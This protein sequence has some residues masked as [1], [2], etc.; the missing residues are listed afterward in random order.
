M[1]TL[2]S[3]DKRE[4]QPES[5]NPVYGGM[6]AD[7]YR[8]LIAKVDFEAMPIIEKAVHKAYPLPKQ[9]P[10]REVATTGH[11]QQLPAGIAA[12]ALGKEV[13]Q[14]LPKETP[15][16]PQAE[17]HVPAPEAVLAKSQADTNPSPKAPAA[18]ATTVE[19]ARSL[20]QAAYG[21]AA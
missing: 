4:K 11:A 15:T 1:F 17:K 19:D 3:D 18:G 16:V 9:S 20:L 13:V 5:I 6:D 12:P 14:E 8:H 10:Q 2:F 7:M 21:K